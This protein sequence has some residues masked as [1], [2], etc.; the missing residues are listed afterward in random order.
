MKKIE[1]FVIGIP[2]IKGSISL[3]LSHSTEDTAQT[4]FCK[5]GKIINIKF[6]KNT[7]LINLFLNLELCSVIKLYNCF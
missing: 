7:F 6:I 4:I 2:V 1:A 5:T 3:F